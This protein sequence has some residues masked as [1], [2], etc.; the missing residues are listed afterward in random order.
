MQKGQEDLRDLRVLLGLDCHLVHLA[1]L[2]QWDLHL[3]HQDRRNHHRHLADREDL[4][5]QLGLVVLVLRWDPGHQAAPE[6][7]RVLQDQH[8]CMC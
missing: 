1:Q 2:A 4:G 8:C 5:Y 7:P 3:Q 6:V